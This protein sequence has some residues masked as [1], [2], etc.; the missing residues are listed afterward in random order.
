MHGLLYIYICISL[1][2]CHDRDSYSEYI[3]KDSLST[4][5]TLKENI[6]E[7]LLN[8]YDISDIDIRVNSY[9]KNFDLGK[10][11][12]I[13]YS[14]NS[15]VVW[16]PAMHLERL[17]EMCV[18]WSS[19]KSMYYHNDK[20]STY[21]KSL[22][23]YWND[24]DLYNSDSWWWNSIGVSKRLG[25]ALILF[26]C[27][28]FIEDNIYSDL[29]NLLNRLNPDDFSSGTN[30]TDI[31]IYHFYKG[32]LMKNDS[33]VEKCSKLVLSSATFDNRSNNGFLIDGSVLS[34]DIRYI[35]G[36]G[37][38]LLLNIL[39]MASFV[40]N[41]QFLEKRVVDFL[42]QYILSTYQ[43]VLR[44]PYIDFLAGG[45][46]G[47]SRP[48][49]LKNINSLKILR[50]IKK[51]DVDSLQQ[52][53]I[54][55]DRIR[56]ITSPSSGV[57]DF[58]KI[59]YCSDY[60]IHNSDRFSITVA[61]TSKR[62]KK[63]EK[64]NGENL[65]GTLLS[66]GAT[67]IRVSGDEYFNI[68]PCWD[69]TLIPGVTSSYILP[70]FEKDWGVYGKS[71]YC[72]GC[73]DKNNNGIFSLDYTD[74]GVS[75]RKSYFFIP[76]GAICIGTNISSSY[77]D[78]RTC[79]NQC[80]KV[81]EVIYKYV[82]E[83]NNL[84]LSNESVL[85]GHFDYVY[86]NNIYY[87][88]LDLNVFHISYNKRESSWRLINE[89]YSSDCSMEVFTMW[90]KHDITDNYA[91]A[92]IPGIDNFKISDLDI[93]SIYY[94]K[95]IH[96]IYDKLSHVLYVSF[97][98]SGKYTCMNNE[99]EVSNPCSLIY[100]CDENKGWVV[101]PSQNLHYIQITINNLSQL[102]YFPT[103]I[104]AGKQIDFKF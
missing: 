10:F 8:N 78:L 66:C 32:V 93:Y 27:D 23:E 47:V 100:Y 92:L 102:I 14:D 77:S 1:C 25:E 21:I 36:Y 31:A 59:F 3:P 6:S 98:E 99:I 56:M 26:D 13:D 33:I 67:S 71:D 57:E 60:A 103:G 75:A 65:L 53:N 17:R 7:E 40:N 88:P 89:G 45:R 9:L 104:Y 42:S 4:Y 34:D 81:G 37:E 101:D 2:S 85:E 48:D 18:A 11:V 63:P 83:A 22:F 72:G 73:S 30:Q 69:W 96:A 95:D 80:A 70:A 68:F 28:N 46:G 61:G 86:H 79:V 91:Y 84:L 29:I 97:F 82:G 35:S 15:V 52:Y 62:I 16:K 41:T 76:Q 20:M 43:N 44:G 5:S 49:F 58:T 94:S 38:D 12:D 39:Q 64:G 74:Y 19:P 87:I 54:I 55:E 50:L 51:I 90:V 24:A